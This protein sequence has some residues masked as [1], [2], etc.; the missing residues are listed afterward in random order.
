[1][2]IGLG[3]G[4]NV[5]SFH[6]HPFN[7]CKRRC[8]FQFST[9]FLR[10]IFCLKNL[11]ILNTFF[12]GYLK[13]KNPRWSP[14]QPTRMSAGTM[15]L[16]QALENVD[17]D[18][19]GS[20]HV[21]PSVVV[22]TSFRGASSL[23]GDPFLTGDPGIPEEECFFMEFFV[24]SYSFFKNAPCK[25]VIWSIG[26]LWKNWPLLAIGNFQVQILWEESAAG[27]TNHS[28]DTQRGSSILAIFW[29]WG[30][31]FIGK[32]TIDSSFWGGNPFLKFF[33]GNFCILRIHL[34]NLTWKLQRSPW[35]KRF[36]TW[37]PSFLASMLNF[38]GVFKKTYPFE[39]HT[40]QVFF[41]QRLDWYLGLFVPSK[42][43][44]GEVVPVKLPTLPRSETWL[45]NASSHLC[46]LGLG[47]NDHPILQAG[48]PLW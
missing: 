8:L 10:H 23:N 25:C 37:K 35:K 42:I 48:N 32:S 16:Y 46:E 40:P 43:W 30:V 39:I 15:S 27:S 3:G 5:D 47:W 20:R 18:V 38:G 31:D 44:D 41:Q 17:E 11:Y 13:E 36:R 24:V 34:W 2:Y 7:N 33:N 19:F 9:H 4:F 1:M 26:K 6:F 45:G 14:R 12:P 28:R 22:P 21:G 29:F